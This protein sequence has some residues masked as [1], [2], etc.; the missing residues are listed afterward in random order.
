MEVR[1][2]AAHTLAALHVVQ[3]KTAAP[4]AWAADMREALGGIAAAMDGMSREAWEEDPLLQA[5]PAK[6]ASF[7]VLPQDPLEA[8]PVAFGFLHG[9][10]DWVVAL[11]R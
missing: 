11:L 8:F 5:S 2:S 4:I 9:Y 7:P 1:K 6:P 3:G 10:L